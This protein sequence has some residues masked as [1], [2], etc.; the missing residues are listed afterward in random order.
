MVSLGTGEHRRRRSDARRPLQ[1]RVRRRRR[2]RGGGRRHREHLR[3]RGGVKNESVD[4]ILAAA[5]LKAES[6]QKKKVVVT[7]CLAQRYAEDLAEE[8]PEV[9]IVM[10]FEE[11]NRPSTVGT[12]LGVETNADPSANRGRVRVGTASPPFAPRRFV[13]ASPRSTTP[14][15]ASPVATT[16]APSAPSRVSAASSEA[17]RGTLSSRRQR[18]WRRRAPRSSASSPRTPTSGAWTSRR[19]GRGLAELL[20][21][22]AEVD[23]GVDRILY[24]TP[25]S[26]ELIDAIADIPQVAKY[27]DIP[28]QHITN[29]CCA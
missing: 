16:S 13:S 15:S 23:G 28:L 6:G 24:G 21:A 7:G 11:Y 18:R 12:M 5:A 20:E 1:Q 25:A 27:I 8:L 26:Q 22:L 19:D 14:T 4:A 2:P 9:D 3:V 29:L 17:S 10:G